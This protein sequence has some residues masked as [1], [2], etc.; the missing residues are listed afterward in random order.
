MSFKTN[1]IRK[2]PVKVISNK[3]K[4][5]LKKAK[6]IEIKKPV[7]NISRL[8]LNKGVSFSIALISIIMI[9]FIFFKTFIFLKDFSL[10]FLLSTGLGIVDHFY[11]QELRQDNFQRTNVLVLGIGGENHYGGTLTDTILVGSYNHVKKSATMLS[12]PRDLYVNIDT[13]Y[14]HKLNVAHTYYNRVYGEE[15]AYEKIQQLIGNITGLK[16]HYTIVLDFEAF[17]SVVNTLDGIEIDVPEPLIDTLYPLEDASGNFI[18]HMTFRVDAGPQIMDGETALKYVRSRQSTSDFDRGLR[19]QL[20]IKAIKDKAIKTNYITNINKLQ[21]MYYGLKQNVKT[22][23]NINEIVRAAYLAKNIDNDNILKFN[24]NDNMYTPGG[25]LYTPQRDYFDGLS[26]LLPNGATVY[27]LNY[28]DDIKLFADLITLYPEV[29]TYNHKILILN[30]T[31]IEGLATNLQN[32]LTR[33]GFARENIQVGNY[34]TNT[35]NITF[36]IC[37]NELS[38]ETFNVISFFIPLTAKCDLVEIDVDSEEESYDLEIILGK[39]YRR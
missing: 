14:R 36:G 10:D 25:F 1:K 37:K 35:E 31:N 30:G 34:E 20:V 33:I 13:N 15:L 39:D 23:M 9:F 12:I 11:G 18:R 4:D 32:K 2:K 27:N 22:N 3:I 19:Q 6:A 8:K 29:Y 16:I 17:V 38:Q 24:I 7:L 28:Y 26:V 21:Q 5:S